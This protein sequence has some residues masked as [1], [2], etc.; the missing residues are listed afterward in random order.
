MSTTFWQLFGR[1]RIT[2]AVAALS[3]TLTL[4]AIRFATFDDVPTRRGTPQT[5]P[6]RESQATTSGSATSTS[7]EL[8]TTTRDAQ[9]TEPAPSTTSPSTADVLLDTRGLGVTTFGT[10]ATTVIALL[11]A[12]LGQPDTDTGFVLP[13]DHQVLGACP[14]G[15]QR[16]V[17]WGDLWVGFLDGVSDYA[18]QPAPHFLNY[19]YGDDVGGRDEM[20]LETPQGIS[21]GS[22]QQ[23]VLA[24]YGTAATHNPGDEL[25]DP[26]VEVD[27]GER[28]PFTFKLT[29]ND[30]TS[31]HAGQPCG[32]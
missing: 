30:V 22:S 9:P 26:Y 21:V 6:S 10:D 15:N 1:R 19:S 31:I 3:L 29:S 7:T 25:V 20:L 27:L 12:Q 11:T 23:E 28:F 4:V 18:A 17:V 14:P 13:S 2:F 5:D 32:Q 16:A 8:G 24:E